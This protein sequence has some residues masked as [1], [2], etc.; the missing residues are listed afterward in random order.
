M[1]SVYFSEFLGLASS[2][3]QFKKFIFFVLKTNTQPPNPCGFGDVFTSNQKS[4]NVANGVRWCA[5]NLVPGSE[6]GVVAVVVWFVFAVGVLITH[7]RG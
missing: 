4:N 5:I 2:L 3:I 6:L 7:A 1:N